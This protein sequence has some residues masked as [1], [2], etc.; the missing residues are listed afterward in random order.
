[1]DLVG[2]VYA[3]AIWGIKLVGQSIFSVRVCIFTWCWWTIGHIWD[4]KHWKAHSYECKKVRSAI[5]SKFFSQLF[6]LHKIDR[7]WNLTESTQFFCCFVRLI[8]IQ[9]W[10]KLIFCLEWNSKI[11]EIAILNAFTYFNIY[12]SCAHAF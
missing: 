2:C 4:Q 10:K 7:E 3:I 5:D 11:N 9:E 12:I 8:H 6:F 1:M